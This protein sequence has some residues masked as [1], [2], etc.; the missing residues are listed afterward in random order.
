M[1]NSPIP[2]ALSALKNAGYLIQN[3]IPEKIQDTPWSLVLR[4]TTAQ[5]FIYLKK[6]PKA[7]ALESDLINI[8]HEQFHAPVPLIIADNP[9]QHCF[10]MR[11]VG[12]QLHDFFK[13][14]FQAEL[15][16]KAMQNYSAMQIKTADKLEL[17]LDRGV[18]DWRLE[19]LPKLYQALIT[20]ENFLSD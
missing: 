6:V 18:P 17:F 10:L 15:F 4:F 11:D 8:L 2:W 19:Q 7:L 5:G 13:E 3:T 1:N 9:K 20:K 14:G 12:I 16:I